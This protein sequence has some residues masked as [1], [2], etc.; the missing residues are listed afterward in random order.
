[1]SICSTL[2]NNCVCHGISVEYRGFHLLPGLRHLQSPRQKMFFIT[3]SFKVFMLLES[4]NYS[5]LC[6]NF[7]TC[8]LKKSKCTFPKI[9]SCLACGVVCTVPHR[10]TCV[11]QWRSTP[12]RQRFIQHPQEPMFYENPNQV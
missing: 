12:R 1:M 6:G 7:F 5:G 8:F 10:N 9:T 2:H 11:Q 4:Y 3:P